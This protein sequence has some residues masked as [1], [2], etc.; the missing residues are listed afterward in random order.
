ML[1]GLTPINEAC[2]LALLIRFVVGLVWVGLLFYFAASFHGRSQQHH[3][4]YANCRL[5]AP[6]VH[7]SRDE[8]SSYLLAITIVLGAWWWSAIWCW[9]S[10]IRS[11][12]RRAVWRTI[13]GRLSIGIILGLG[14]WI[15]STH[16]DSVR[17]RDL[18]SLQLELSTDRP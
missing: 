4:S 15:V 11:W 6:Q 3:T 9:W 7:H 14:P 12:R 18:Y 17:F 2:M 16:S 13:R 8:D 10:S 1:S 5:G